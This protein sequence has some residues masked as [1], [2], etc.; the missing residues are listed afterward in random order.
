VQADE[1]NTTPRVS[2]SQSPAPSLQPPFPP[3]YAIIDADVSACAGWTVADLAAALL[4]GGARL[5]QLRAKLASGR[6]FLRWA[7]QLVDKARPAGAHIIINDRADVAAMAAAD[8]AH[9]GQDDLPPRRV[10]DWL[11]PVAWVGLS[12]YTD[13]QLSDGLAEPVSY[14]AVGPVFAT[15][16]K[17]TG[18]P[19][20][21]LDL[22]RRAARILAEHASQTGRARMPLVAI[23]GITLD[24]APAVIR[25][26][27]DSVAV[28]SD[29]LSTGDPAGRT[30]AFLSRLSCP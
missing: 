3:L 2:T 6:D 5:I 28:V 22:V 27:A 4:D 30:R 9:V 17:E 26:G 24:Q 19:A 20:G 16:T 25:A 8:G 7:E 14:L 13:I 11:G 10:R 18:Y 23:G 1:L 29:L 15:G 12:T 21:G